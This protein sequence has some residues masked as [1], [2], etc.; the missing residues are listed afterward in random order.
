MKYL[1]LVLA[2]TGCAAPGADYYLQ[3]AIYNRQQYYQN[4]A[5]IYQQPRTTVCEVDH[6]NPRITRCTQK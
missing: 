5:Q 1:P 4:K 3:E 2:L 6:F